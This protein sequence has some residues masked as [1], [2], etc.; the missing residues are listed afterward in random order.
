MMG[1][2][3]SHDRKGSMYHDHGDSNYGKVKMPKCC[4]D[5]GETVPTAEIT[6]GFEENG[7]VVMLSA[8]ELKTVAANTG[9]SVEVPHFVKSDQ[10]DPMLF[11]SENVYRL[12]PDIK[13]GRQAMT[14]YV[15]IRRILTDQGLVGVVQYTRWGRNQLGLLD[16]EPSDDG[17][18][19]I[20]RNMGWPDELR[21]AENSV[22][23]N[24]SDE[25]I[26]PRLLPVMESVVE[27]MTGN[28]NPTEYTDAYNA[29]LT[30]AIEAKAAGNEIAAISS[31]G[32]DSINDIDD[33]LAKLESSVK[34]AAPAKKAAPRKRAAKKAAPRRKKAA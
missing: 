20:I 1:V 18:V 8:E 11:A 28:W 3:D 15:M 9:A 4:Q 27:S 17:G 19:L 25:D 13:R 24:A 34:K 14:T 16:V 10:V 26:D 12:V 29:R 7:A 5:C 32:S 30:E 23:A 21:P 6:K 22:L 33:L 2:S 31:E